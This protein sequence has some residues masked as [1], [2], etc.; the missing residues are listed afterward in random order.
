MLRKLK[1]ERG[2]SGDVF[3]SSDTANFGENERAIN[4]FEKEKL[5]ELI[6]D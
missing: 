3:K 2:I 6:E 5:N 4:Q 1:K